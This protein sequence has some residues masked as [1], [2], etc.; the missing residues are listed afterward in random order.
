MHLIKTISF[1]EIYQ[2]WQNHLWP[3]RRSPI[4]SNSAMCY[5]GGYDMYNMNTVPSFFGLFV[6]NQLAGVNSGHMCKNREY[7]SRGLFV[8][9]EHRGRGFGTELLLRT[10]AQGREENA[11]LCWSYPRKNSWSTYR[12]SGFSLQSAF[13]QDETGLNAYCSIV[14]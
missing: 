4:E 14:L 12:R 8:F 2:I 7:R 9:D 13:K 1:E 11:V 6:D 10:V 3:G 5:L